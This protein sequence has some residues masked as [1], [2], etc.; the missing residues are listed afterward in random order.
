M[1]DA[2]WG[3]LGSRYAVVFFGWFL[4]MLDNQVTWV[5][6]HCLLCLLHVHVAD[7]VAEVEDQE[8]HGKEFPT[9]LVHP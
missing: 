8:G 3:R 1:I 5:A 4:F 7:P 6:I 9:K 2:N